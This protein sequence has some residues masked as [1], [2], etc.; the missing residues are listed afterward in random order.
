MQ[1]NLKLICERAMPE[2]QKI[3][4]TGCNYGETT[5]PHP[6]IKRPTNY[7]YFLAGLVRSR[8]MTD[9]LGHYVHEKGLKGGKRA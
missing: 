6:F 7:Y 4:L 1:D 5:G 9:I 8:G 3:D 2:G